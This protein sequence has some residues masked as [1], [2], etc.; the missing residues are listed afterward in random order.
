MGFGALQYQV[1]A[2]VVLPHEH[3][4][5]YIYVCMKV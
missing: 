2:A 5:D 1:L 4:S 3:Q